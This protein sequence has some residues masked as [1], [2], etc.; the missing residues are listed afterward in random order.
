MNKWKYKNLQIRH[1][2]DEEREKWTK[3]ALSNGYH[4]LSSYVR[5]LLKNYEDIG[6]E[7]D[8][9]DVHLAISSFDPDLI[10]CNEPKKRSRYVR[11]FINQKI[12]GTK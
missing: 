7:N 10:L 5:D 8:A 4:T 2:T 1:C 12:K 9:G 11:Y 6:Y 3:K